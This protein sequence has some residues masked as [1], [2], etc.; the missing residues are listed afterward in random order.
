MN[1]KSENSKKSNPPLAETPEGTSRRELL[2]GGAGLVAG[3][4]AASLLPTEALAAQPN[5]NGNSNSD[6]FGRLTRANADSARSILLQGGTVITMDPNVPDL[7]KGDVL[8]QGKKIAAV[9]PDLG[10]AAGNGNTV[11]VD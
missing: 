10:A 5:G 9:G 3:A 11:V 4:A 1:S 6:I 8:I 2:K 7:V